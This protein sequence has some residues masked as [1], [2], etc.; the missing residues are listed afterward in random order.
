MSLIDPI[1]QPSYP[2][3]QREWEM[4]RLSILKELMK[5]TSLNLDVD[6]H[7]YISTENIIHLTFLAINNGDIK[8]LELLAKDKVKILSSVFTAAFFTIVTFQRMNWNVKDKHGLTPIQVALKKNKEAL[9][10]I[11]MDI[12]EV[13][14]SV[15]PPLLVKRSLNRKRK[16]PNEVVVPECPVCLL[17]LNTV[18]NIFQCVR[19]HFVCGVCRP[20][21]MNCPQCRDAIMGRAYGMENFLQDNLK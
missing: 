2:V 19:G 4:K 5:I 9:F 3:S 16:A 20:N 6:D 21:V 14:K 1:R 15:L 12:P 7:Q 18:Q 17:E 8:I 11:L 10:D 13:D